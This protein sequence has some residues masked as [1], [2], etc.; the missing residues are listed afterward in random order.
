[1]FGLQGAEIIAHCDAAGLKP[2]LRNRS[3]AQENSCYVPR[4]NHCGSEIVDYTG[5]VLARNDTL[6]KKVFVKARVDMPGLRNYRLDF[7]CNLVRLT[8]R[9][10]A[11]YYETI[12]TWPPNQFLKK[13]PTNLQKAKDESIK[14]AWENC[15][16]L[17][18]LRPEALEDQERG[19]RSY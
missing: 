12:T 5:R 8:T 14:I 1:M 6:E 15:L 10:F 11:H 3:M 9:I 13:I 16:K 17:G 18:I 19:V 4:A 7:G 2:R